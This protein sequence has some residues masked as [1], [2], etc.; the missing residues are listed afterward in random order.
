MLRMVWRQR[1]KEHVDILIWNYKYS[2][3]GLK[4]TILGR[5][6]W[7]KEAREQCEN[8][9]IC[10][11]WY[12]LLKLVSSACIAYYKLY[13]SLFWL[14]HD[15]MAVNLGCD[16]SLIEVDPGLQSSCSVHAVNRPYHCMRNYIWIIRY[17]ALQEI[18]QGLYC[19][20]SQ[21]FIP[22]TIVL[23]VDFQSYFP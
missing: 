15:D 21:P 2:F 22:W 5:M 9:A 7:M 10:C 4:G 3:P 12:H 6:E 14:T 8:D 17:K 1:V 19:Y 20:L 11:N 13:D 16:Y 18:M 23:A